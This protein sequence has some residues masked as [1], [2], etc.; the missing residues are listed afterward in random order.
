MDV[1]SGLT[2]VGKVVD[3]FVEAGWMAAG[4]VVV[5]DVDSGC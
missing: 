2:S 1:D 5:V 4:R 3:C